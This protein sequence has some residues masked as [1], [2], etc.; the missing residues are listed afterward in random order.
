MTIE[1]AIKRPFQNIEKLAIGTIISAV[2][3]VN[4]IAVGYFL[5]CFR[6]T[7]RKDNS[8]PEWADWSKIILD[9]LKAA[10]VQIV[11][12]IPLMILFLIIFA[13]FAGFVLT[14]F[15]PIDPGTF[16]SSQPFTQAD[17]AI[18]FTT[19]FMQIFFE[20]IGTLFFGFFIF[21]SVAI[22]TSLLSTAATVRFAQTENFNSAFALGEVKSVGL[23]LKFFITLIIA[24]VVASVVGLVMVIPIALL[25]LIPVLGVLINFLGSGLITFVGGL[26]F[27]T[28][29]AERYA[30]DFQPTRTAVAKTS[31]KK[32]RK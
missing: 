21:I 26:I 25:T 8:L 4:L 24:G 5:E 17:T 12:A 31:A 10:V 3:L 6:R 15:G 19:K 11:Y 20:N 27:W 22:I 29:L 18:K 16:A 32:K 2:P 28:I 1:E 9:G 14:V 30:R 23:T 7:L 13:I